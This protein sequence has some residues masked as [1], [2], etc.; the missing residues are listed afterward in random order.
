MSSTR[1][2]RADGCSLFG[3][4]IVATILVFAF[5][6]VRQCVP[7]TEETSVDLMENEER[8]KKVDAYKSEEE[9]FKTLVDKAHADINSS[10]QKVMQET[11][12]AYSAEQGESGE[13]GES[14]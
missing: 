11:L 9:K 12:D 13:G 6:I 10:F 2:Q 7:S 4:L 5:F 3:S 8:R 1:L 14:E